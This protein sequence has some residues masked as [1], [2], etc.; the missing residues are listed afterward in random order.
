MRLNVVF[1]LILPLVLTAEI[2]DKIDFNKH[3]RPL[4]SDR[5][6]KCHGP[7][8][9]KYGEAWKGG[10][11]LDIEEGAK[12]DLSAVKL[13]VKNTKLKPDPSDD[14]DAYVGLYYFVKRILPLEIFPNRLSTLSVS[15]PG[16]VA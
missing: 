10:L 7:D 3:I 12:A 1:F 5:C 4:L 2:P 16:I 6:F 11:R 15:V 9:G 8:G 14:I 13:Q